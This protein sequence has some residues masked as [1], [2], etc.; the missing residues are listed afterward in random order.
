MA[1]ATHDIIAETDQDRPRDAGLDC[2]RRRLQHVGMRAFGENKSLRRTLRR[3]EHRLHDE[4][5]AIDEGREFVCVGLEVGNGAGGDAGLHGGGGDGRCDFRDQP[6][7][8]RFRQ[9]VIRTKYE[10]I[11]T[12]SR[13][14]DIGGGLVG[15][16]GERL[17][18]GL[19]HVLVDGGGAAIEGTAEDEREA[20]HVVDLVGK[21]CAARG[22]DRIFANR[23][24]VFRH[25]LW[26]GICE[27]ENQWFGAHA[28]HH[29]PRYNA[30]GRKAEE[31]IGA[32][33]HFGKCARV[34][35]L[36]ERLFVGVH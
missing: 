33:H 36:A 29:F 19:L 10:G 27:R 31:D 28:G 4:A 7:I 32:R 26:V 12:V 18:G 8:E 23:L 16:A 3:L 6:R 11:G 9:D 17:H 13:G 24:D 21:V 15:N 25:D 34:G 14:D 2:L 20:Q 1:C 30:G 22:D 35:L 5:R